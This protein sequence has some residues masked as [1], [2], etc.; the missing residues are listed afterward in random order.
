MSSD[1]KNKPKGRLRRIVFDTLIVIVITVCLIV[2]VE[3]VLRLFAPQV[4]HGKSIIG[5]TFSNKDEILGYRYTPG[6]KWRFTHPEYSV[7]YTINMQGF[8]DRKEHVIPKPE[9]VVRVLLVGDS[10]TFGQGVDYEETW[11]VLVEKHLDESG[12]GHIELIKAGIQGMDTRS[13]FILIQRLLE[14]YECD[15]VVLGFLINDLYTNSLYGIDDWQTFAGQASNLNLDSNAVSRQSWSKTVQKVFMHNDQRNSFHLLTLVKRVLTS[16]DAAYCRLYLMAPNR[17][18]WLTTPLA[19]HLKKKLGIT[20]RLFL[21]IVDY[22]KNFGAKFIVLSMPQQ[23]QVLFYEQAK[24]SKDI[25][26]GIYDRHFEELA[27][28]QS[29]V[30][31]ST[32]SDFT[33]SDHK[34]EEL[35]YRLD[36]HLTPKG[37]QIAAKSF[38]K[39]IV[40]LL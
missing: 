30:W 9:G 23:F 32:L 33:D 6:S 35:F 29:F 3:G 34:K 38:I 40:P 4:L 5:E 18:D 10:F 17:G 13:E 28:S 15:A 19:P 21:R 31:V 25:D 36:G 22:C 12:K 14:K 37:N 1:S 11:P 7:E 27:E 16:N 24:L 8:R 2:I 39:N 20:Q 26:V